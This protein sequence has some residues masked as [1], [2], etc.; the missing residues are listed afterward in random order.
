MKLIFKL[1]LSLL[2]LLAIVF[3]V[4]K[5]GFDYSLADAELFLIS[6][7]ET[8]PLILGLTII[9]LM[10]VDLFLAIPTVAVIILAGNFLGFYMGSFLSILGAYFL[11]TL[12]YFLG[13]IMGPKLISIITKDKKE[14]ESMKILFN[15]NGH[16][17]L[18]MGRAC[19]MLP[20]ISSCL[21]GMGD[22]KYREFLKWYM[23]G[24]IPYILLVSFCGSISRLD[25]LTP[26]ILMIFLIYASYALF[27]L[28]FKSKNKKAIS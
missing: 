7:K 2:S 18:L 14:V 8:H 12:G 16:L 25:N 22:M 5:I 24:A 15:K 13:Q 1:V 4:G 10:I 3:L 20:E 17:S 11:G 26:L 23:A 21:A 28:Y 27:G 6:I 19:P 9:L